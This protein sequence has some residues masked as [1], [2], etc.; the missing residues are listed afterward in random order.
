MSCH[1]MSCH[2]MSCHVMSCHVMSYHISYHIIYIISYIISYHTIPYHISYHI[3][4][5]HC[6]AS[7]IFRQRIFEILSTLFNIIPLLDTCPCRPKC[8]CLCFA[9]KWYLIFVNNVIFCRL[10][11]TTHCLIVYVITQ[12]LLR[13]ER[14]V[15]LRF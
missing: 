15:V 8:S 4:S 13:S 6:H 12:H 2:I 14:F 7:I 5:Y 10:D 3:I 1:V 11:V 9:I